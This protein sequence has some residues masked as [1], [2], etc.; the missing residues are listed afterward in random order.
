MKVNTFDEA[1]EMVDSMTIEEREQLLEIL[2]KRL[3]DEKRE[4]L[5]K[6][7]REAKQEYRKGKIKKGTVDDLMREIME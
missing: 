6:N 5:V 1:L 3:I 2:Q 4:E 7:I